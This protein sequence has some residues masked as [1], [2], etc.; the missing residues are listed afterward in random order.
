[1]KSACAILLAL[2]V[3]LSGVAGCTWSADV[4]RSDGLLTGTPDG[5]LDAGDSGAACGQAAG[6]KALPP[7]PRPAA[8]DNSIERAFLYNWLKD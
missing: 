3:T 4:P 1:M 2:I 6:S 7:D 8:S 5:S